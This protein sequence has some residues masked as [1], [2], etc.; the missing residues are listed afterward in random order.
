MPK[1]RLHLL[2]LRI[3][4]NIMKKIAIALALILLAA[5]VYTAITPYRVMQSMQT[6]IK[7]RDAD[8]LNGHIDFDALRT[9]IKAQYFTAS[10][11]SSE[12]SSG[13]TERLAQGM[14]KRMV[15]GVQHTAVNI[16]VRPVTV[17]A[18]LRGQEI[19]E[20]QPIIGDTVIPLDTQSPLADSRTTYDSLSQFSIWSNHHGSGK[21]VRIILE[22]QFL[23]WKVTNVKVY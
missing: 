4:P 11:S 6:A 15:Q 7:A 10:V 3:T 17:T 18:I 21:Q 2:H 14:A 5:A 19:P 8:T 23:Q 1:T 9:N 22:R 20:L 12:G 13:L 16:L